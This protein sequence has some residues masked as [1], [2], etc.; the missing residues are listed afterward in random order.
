MII[1][2]GTAASGLDIFTKFG[3]GL[4][5]PLS[6]TYEIREPGGSLIDAASG[7]RISVGH[8]DARNSI[9]PSGFD[10]SS[11]WTIR[12][13]FIAPNGVSGCAK[14][15][16]T[17]SDIPQTFEL[18]GNIV[19]N[20]KT[21]LGL[22][23]DAFTTGEFARFI[24]KAVKRINRRLCFTG[25]AAE[26]TFNTLTGQISPVPDSTI[27]DFILMQ[28]ECMISKRN[29]NVGIRKGI[30]V[31]DGETEI[32]TTAGFG[33]F[34]DMIKSF[35]GELDEAVKEFFRKEHE[36]LY[37]NVTGEVVW[38]GNR[39]IC[40]DLFHNGQGHGI[41]RCIISPFEHSFGHAIAHM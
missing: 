41:T 19:E 40:E 30:R 16:F 10:N 34:S 36:D 15:N 35:C 21:D 28:A 27:C 8:F 33:G 4:A 14:E 9:I 18:I 13:D 24:D 31:K 2:A 22:L 32:D 11:A 12:W 17:V 29:F 39:N 25:T 26:L 6:I 23:D 20:L 7:T 37:R 5:D 3:A 38:Y 1:V